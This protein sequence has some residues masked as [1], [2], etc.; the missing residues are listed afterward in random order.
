MRPVASR[1]GCRAHRRAP[2]R[3][4]R[5]MR[6]ID[7]IASAPTDGQRVSNNTVTVAPDDSRTTRLP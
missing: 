2:L 7:T 5:G 1:E 4:L 6:E 3:N